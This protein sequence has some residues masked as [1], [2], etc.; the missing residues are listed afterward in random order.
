MSYLEFLARSYNLVFLALGVLGAGIL[1]WSRRREEDLFLAHAGLIALAVA[2]LTLNGAIHD[3]ALG[4]PADRFPA[5]LGLSVVI[6]AAA[7]GVGRLVRDRFFPPVREVHFNERGLEGVEARIVSR[8]VDGEPGSG[9]AHW[10]DGDGGLHL[11]TCHT[12]EGRLEFGTTVR[13]EAFDDEHGS[14]LVRPT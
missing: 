4:D 13:L 1:W 14:Y 12:D 5:V 10:H 8:S 9:R 3:L 7:A 6:A 11:V 2:G